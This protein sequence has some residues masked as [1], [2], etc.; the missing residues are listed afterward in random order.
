MVPRRLLLV[1]EGNF[2][3][4]V[5]LIN[6]LDPG[7]SITATCLQHP[8]DLEEDPVTQENLQRLR[9][10]GSVPPLR[11]ARPRASGVW[12]AWGM[13]VRLLEA[14]PGSAVCPDLGWF[15]LLC[16]SRLQI[17]RLLL[18]YI[19]T[20]LHFLCQVLKSV[21]VW[22]A[23]SWHTPCRHTT[24]TLIEFIST[25]RTVDEKLESLRTGNCLP[26]F[27]RGEERRVLAWERFPG[28]HKQVTAHKLCS[29]G[30]KADVC[31]LLGYTWKEDKPRGN[32]NLVL[33]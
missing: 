33:K 19:F 21:F 4:T 9:E 7:V 25:S 23:P 28:V 32:H 15:A 17:L 31:K 11:Q 20:P 5:S 27:S 12:L 24:E 3:F 16:L 30:N 8:A 29:W 14:L 10:R 13:R 6:T 26:S 22:I 2:S 18:V 1:G